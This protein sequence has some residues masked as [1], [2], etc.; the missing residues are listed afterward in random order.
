[1]AMCDTL[2]F[3]LHHI[4]AT[5]LLIVLFMTPITFNCISIST[6]QL[7]PIFRS[8]SDALDFR[9]PYL[10]YPSL[11]FLQGLHIDSQCLLLMETSFVLVL[12]KVG[13]SAQGDPVW[14][15][16]LPTSL[17]VHSADALIPLLRDGVAKALTSRTGYQRLRRDFC[18]KEVIGHAIERFSRWCGFWF[19]I[20]L[21]YMEMFTLHMVVKLYLRILM[22]RCSPGSS[23]RVDVNRFECC[24]NPSLEGTLF[25]VTDAAGRT[26][27]HLGVPVDVQAAESPVPLKPF[28]AADVRD[29]VETGTSHS[30]NLKMLRLSL[31]WSVEA[32]IVM[33]C[34]K[35]FW[36]NP[37]ILFEGF[38]AFR[39]YKYIYNIYI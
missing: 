33:K 2:P 18:W 34:S 4:S 15:A 39:T 3:H 27:V 16:G 9:Y 5:V 21:L 6:V 31:G 37:A 25:V 22:I 29:D 8:L 35:K 24:K 23:I 30:Y 7:T 20:W 12:A 19:L 26:C 11:I 38:V 14:N 1:M 32:G 13:S 28:C 10:N 36:L 17:D